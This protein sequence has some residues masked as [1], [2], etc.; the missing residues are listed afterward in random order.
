MDSRQLT[1][2]VVNVNWIYIRWTTSMRWSKDE[3][4][5]W[6]MDGSLVCSHTYIHS[7]Y[8]YICSY[9]ECK[10]NLYA[11][12]SNSL[13]SCLYVSVRISLIVS[14]RKEEEKYERCWFVSKSRDVHK[15]SQFEN[16]LNETVVQSIC[17]LDPRCVS[18]FLS[19]GWKLLYFFFCLVFRIS[20]LVLSLCVY[21]Y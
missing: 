10:Q 3:K 1:L 4:C 16:E 5:N 17:E 12:F 20:P 9:C 11:S 6:Q 13:L 14:V 18:R 8:S 19:Y 7:L 2:S 15:S 21:T